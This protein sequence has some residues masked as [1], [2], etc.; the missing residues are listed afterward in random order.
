LAT[1]DDDDRKLTAYLD[2]ELDEAEQAALEARLKNE[3]T[4]RARLDALRVAADR[5]RSDYRGDPHN[6]LTSFRGMAPARQDQ[7]RD[8]RFDAVW[9]PRDRWSVKF[10]EVKSSRDSNQPGLHYKDVSTQLSVQYKFGN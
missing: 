9:T 5:T 8:L 2:R 6:L 10:D 1:S 3:P 4:L 7:V